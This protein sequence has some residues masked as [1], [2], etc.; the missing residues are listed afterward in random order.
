M[1]KKLESKKKD[2]EKREWKIDIHK[3]KHTSQLLSGAVYLY[4]FMYIGGGGDD[5]NDNNDDVC[6]SRNLQQ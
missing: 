2:I 3:G 5:D 1:G 4:L 6:G